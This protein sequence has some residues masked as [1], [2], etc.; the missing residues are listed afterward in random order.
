MTSILRH[1]RQYFEFLAIDFTKNI[2][3]SLCIQIS[4]GFSESSFT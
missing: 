4:M 3:F 1:E 2:V